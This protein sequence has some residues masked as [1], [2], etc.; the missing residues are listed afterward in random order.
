MATSHRRSAAA[1]RTP[2]PTPSLR[3]LIAVA[4]AYAATSAQTSVTIDGAIDATRARA[5]TAAGPSTRLLT[6]RLAVR[7]MTVPPVLPV[8]PAHPSITHKRQHLPRWPVLAAS[9]HLDEEILE[10][11]DGALGREATLHS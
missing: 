4:A 6:E 11:L 7:L 1:K 5:G 9:E 10:T 2:W 8:R 3:P